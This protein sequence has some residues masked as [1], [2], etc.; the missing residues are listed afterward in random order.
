MPVHADRDASSVHWTVDRN[1]ALSHARFAGTVA[2][3]CKIFAKISRWS[4]IAREYGEM[5]DR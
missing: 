1:A 2:E 5:R 3:V 4:E